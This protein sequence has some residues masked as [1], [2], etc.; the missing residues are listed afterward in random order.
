[1]T[2]SMPFVGNGIQSLHS[3][4]DLTN[5]YEIIFCFKDAKLTLLVFFMV[6]ITRLSLRLSI[7]VMGFSGTVLMEWHAHG[8]INGQ[9]GY[10][11]EVSAR[12]KCLL[13]IWG[14]SFCVIWVK[15][16]CF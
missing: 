11:L 5:M 12:V 14:A 15:E 4:I 13:V 6:F 9:L 8:V 16:K 3:E 2:T 10:K 1:M 7:T